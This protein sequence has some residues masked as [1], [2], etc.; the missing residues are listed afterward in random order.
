V[1]KLFSSSTDPVEYK[2][3]INSGRVGTTGKEMK[4]LHKK[5]LPEV[6]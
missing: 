6:V 2:V 3:F 1:K 5:S 4:K